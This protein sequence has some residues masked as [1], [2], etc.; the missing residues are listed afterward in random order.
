MI[1]HPLHTAPVLHPVEHASLVRQSI[2]GA[3]AEASA[4]LRVELTDQVPALAVPHDLS[5]LA[6]TRGR[7]LPA[8]RVTAELLDFT[9]EGL[10]PTELADE[11]ACQLARLL[12]TDRVAVGAVITDNVRIVG[13]VG[14]R[15]SGTLDPVGPQSGRPA[16]RPA[17][18]PRSPAR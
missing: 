7:A 5:G 9:G 11:L 1:C 18:V 17:P 3:L 2:L 16:L 13:A 10:R 8:H 4:A 12:R 14:G 15:S 6:P